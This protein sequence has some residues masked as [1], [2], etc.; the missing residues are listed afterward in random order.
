VD[1]LR[2][3]AKLVAIAGYDGRIDLSTE[4]AVESG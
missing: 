4:F 3:I 2:E 1:E